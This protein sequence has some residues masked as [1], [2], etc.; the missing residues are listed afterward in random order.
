MLTNERSTPSSTDLEPPPI[1]STILRGV[2]EL[3]HKI[4]QKV[5]IV[6][7]RFLDKDDQPKAR[8]AIEFIYSLTDE[9]GLEFDHD[10][11]VLLTALAQ[12]DYP[13]L[14]AFCEKWNITEDSLPA[15][16]IMRIAEPLEY[17]Y[18]P[19]DAQGDGF[20]GA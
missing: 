5:L 12:K 17:S 4:P 6:A 1:V 11:D 10:L 9:R 20:L 14:A 8:E 16:L 3:I 2:L 15:Y 18:I 13:T 19:Y 7:V